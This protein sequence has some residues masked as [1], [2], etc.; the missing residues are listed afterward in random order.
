M[1]EH[2][3]KMNSNIAWIN[4]NQNNTNL[5]MSLDRYR[6]KSERVQIY[7]MVLELVL[8]IQLFLIPQ[9]L[10]MLDFLKMLLSSI[11]QFVCDS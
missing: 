5:N 1:I 2:K 6:V 10:L 11:N 8:L 4:S 7:N 9:Q 3:A